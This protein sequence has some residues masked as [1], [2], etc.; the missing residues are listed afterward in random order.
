VVDPSIP[1][2][3]N[4]Y[5][6]VFNNPFTNVDPTGLDCV[7]FNDA[8]TGLDTSGTPIDHNSDANTC[9]QTGGNWVN[10][11]TFS[12]WTSYYKSGHT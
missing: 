3:W 11:T 6:Y 2:G 5:S 7:Y 4:L 8:G 10:G 9:K 12:Q 1:Q